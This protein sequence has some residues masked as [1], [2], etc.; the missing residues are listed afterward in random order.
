MFGAVN[1]AKNPWLG[2]SQA[3]VVNPLLLLLC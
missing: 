1:L 2:R 3:P